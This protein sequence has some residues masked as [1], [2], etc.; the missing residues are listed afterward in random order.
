MKVYFNKYYT[1]DFNKYNNKRQTLILKI[2]HSWQTSAFHIGMG[3]R[4]AIPTK[5]G[6]ERSTYQTMI[7]IKA[8]SKSGCRVIPYCFY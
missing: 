2:H 7:F 3:R 8:S 6:S 1:H 4:K 5:T